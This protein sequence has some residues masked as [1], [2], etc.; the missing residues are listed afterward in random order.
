LINNQNKNS[1][2][3][4]RFMAIDFGLKRIGIALTDPLKTF[5]YPF[6]TFKN[7]DTFLDRLKK[8]VIEKCVSRIILGIPI[9]ENGTPANLAQQIVELKLKI[10]DYLC[11]PV[12]L[13]D[14]RYT[15]SIAKENIL[16]AVPKK[17]KRRDKGL[18]DQNAAA[19][20]LTEYLQSSN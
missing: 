17:K 16:Q 9:K 6:E 20:I 5:A 2:I 18:I 15:S 7:D 1:F 3:E 10:E 11:L 4:D 19:V 13:W 14:E 12:F 8:L